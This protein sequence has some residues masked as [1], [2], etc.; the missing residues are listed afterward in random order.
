VQSFNKSQVNEL[1]GEGELWCSW[2]KCFT[3]VALS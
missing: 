3:A 1:D 2:E